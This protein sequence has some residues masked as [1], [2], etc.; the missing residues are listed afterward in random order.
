[1]G[2]QDY[3]IALLAFVS[4]DEFARGDRLLARGLLDVGD[5]GAGRI[6]AELVDGKRE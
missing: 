4:A 1:M 5:F 3:R 2:R 6:E